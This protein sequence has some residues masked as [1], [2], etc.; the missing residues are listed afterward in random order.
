MLQRPIR[1]VLFVTFTFAGRPVGALTIAGPV[2]LPGDTT[3]TEFD[4]SGIVFLDTID[5]DGNSRNLTLITSG[6][7]PTILNGA[8]GHTSALDNL[9]TD[10]LSVTEINGGSVTTF[11]DQVYGDPVVP[12]SNTEMTSTG[13]GVTFAS[14]LDSQYGADS[15]LN[16]SAGPRPGSKGPSTWMS[17][18]SRVASIR[19]HRSRGTASA[20]TTTLST[21][22]MTTSKGWSTGLRAAARSRRFRSLRP[23]CW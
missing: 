5:S 8:V 7:G 22:P 23:G 16:I 13:G 20:S 17:S 10:S 19:S 11:G 18:C 15:R 2:I 21:Q 12:G 3:A 9:T 1:L 6:G 4:G 14:T